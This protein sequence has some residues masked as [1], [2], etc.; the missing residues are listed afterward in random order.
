MKTQTIEN[1]TSD[2]LRQVKMATDLLESD[3]GKKI[4]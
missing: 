2:Y 3:F 4:F 1:L